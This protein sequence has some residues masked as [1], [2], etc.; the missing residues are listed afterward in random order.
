MGGRVFRNLGSKVMGSLFKYAHNACQ[1]Y[2]IHFDETQVRRSLARSSIGVFRN[3]LL[4]VILGS[5]G[6]LL[7]GQILNSLLHQN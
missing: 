1:H 4:E 5:F 2:L 3:I 6:L 7:K